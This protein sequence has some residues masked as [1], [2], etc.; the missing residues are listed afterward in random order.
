[1]GEAVHVLIVGA[2]AV[3]CFY[4]SKLQQTHQ[5]RSIHVSLVCRSNYSAIAAGVVAWKR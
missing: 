4:A 2:G 5:G 1:M 3:G